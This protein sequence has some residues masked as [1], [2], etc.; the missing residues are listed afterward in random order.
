M[1]GFDMYPDRVRIQIPNAKELLERGLQ[2][3]LGNNAQWLPCYD[4]IVAWMND[5][6]GRGLLCMGNCGLGKTLICGSILP[7]IILSHCRK[8]MGTF[9]AI[10]INDRTREVML[11]KLAFIDDIG[12]E[13]EAVRFGER[14]LAFS[15]IVDNAEKKSN[16][17]VIT[18][19]LRTSHKTDSDGNVIPSIEYKYGI[20]T[21][22]RL[23]AITKV[24]K[25][26]GKSFRK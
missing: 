2:F 17:L 8:V 14:H 15:E 19:N 11:S 16:L 12:T 25:F 1:Q 23:R 18:T 26:S 4:D 21:L 13:P 5:N 6:Q 20:R 10:D 24:V 7:A 22:D 9:S 3:F